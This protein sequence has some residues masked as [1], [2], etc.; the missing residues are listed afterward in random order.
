MP[1]RPGSTTFSIKGIAYRGLLLFIERNVEGGLASVCAKVDDPN[2]AW[3]LEQPFLAASPYDILPMMPLNAAVASLL[4]VPLAEFAEER[5]SQQAR[6]D[7]SH[8]YRRLMETSSLDDMWKRLPRFG[9]Q[10]YGFGTCE[11]VAG[12]PKFS[13]VKRRGLPRFIYPWYRTMQGAYAAEIV[14]LAGG[15]DVAFEVAEP[16]PEA[17]IENT[18]VVS[19]ETTVTWA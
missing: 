6:Y 7:A 16:T 19:F 1:R 9:M 3:F 13:R 11:A 4:G 2:V 15:T 5:S 17:P 10:Y 8:A 12:G 18:E 14:R